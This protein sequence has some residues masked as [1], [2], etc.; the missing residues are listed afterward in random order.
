MG[1]ERA[2]HPD[3]TAANLAG[4]LVVEIGDE[5]A[6]LAAKELAAFGAEVIRI[7]PP[8]GCDSRS[9][10][11][12]LHGNVGVD[13][14]LYWAY[15]NAG[16]RSLVADITSTA[17]QTV[18]QQLLDQ[19]D[20]LI[21]SSGPG[22]L[23]AAGLSYSDMTRRNPGLIVVSVTPFG[24]DGPWAEYKTSDLVSLALSGFLHDCGY[25]DHSIAPIRP[26]GNQAFNVTSAQ[27]LTAVMLS[28]LWRRTSGVGQLI[29]LSIHD[30]CAITVEYAD[31]YWFYNQASTQRQTARHAFPRPTAPS[32]Y[33]TAD[34]RYIIGSLVLHEPHVWNNVKRWLTEMDLLL[35]FADA[36]YDDP[37]YRRQHQ[38]LINER[39]RVLAGILPADEFYHRGQQAGWLVGTVRYPEDLVADAQLESR[40]FWQPVGWLGESIPMP[41]SALRIDGVAVCIA[42]PPELD[43]ASD[44]VRT[45][46]VGS[47]RPSAA[48]PA[49]PRFRSHRSTS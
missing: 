4:L 19:A 25:D 46:L 12:F 3:R 8:G 6:A 21:D 13:T 38:H 9:W 27:V 7:E 17:D 2:S 16:K 5:W 26:P 22:V 18:L 28:L 42:G 24:L 29:D 23:A 33:E 32:L 48:Q 49:E 31:L 30:C 44:Y 15:Y 20:I 1:E 35:D 11:P 10:A 34:G 40:K 47:G 39:V 45:K 36:R 41:R 37:T 43:E 14:S